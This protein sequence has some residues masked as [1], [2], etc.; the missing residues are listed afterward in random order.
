MRIWKFHRLSVKPIVRGGVRIQYREIA[1]SEE[2]MHAKLDGEM[3]CI[4][5]PAKPF[6]VRWWRMIFPPKAIEC[7]VGKTG[8]LE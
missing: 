4:D 6:Y 7:E 5:A 2:M 8:V 1:F 3:A